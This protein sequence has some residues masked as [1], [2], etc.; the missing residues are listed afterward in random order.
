MGD[1]SV[2]FYRVT[3][4]GDAIVARVDSGVI[5][6]EMGTMAIEGEVR[7][8]STVGISKSSTRSYG[9]IV[10]CKV[11]TLTPLLRVPLF[12]KQGAQG[13]GEERKEKRLG[14]RLFTSSDAQRQ[15]AA[16]QDQER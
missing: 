6:L 11:S 14:T 13:T 16:C 7:V 2:G 15:M 8:N 9:Q 1:F 5:K 3:S 10:R 4:H 12:S